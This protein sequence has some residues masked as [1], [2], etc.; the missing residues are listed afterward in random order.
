MEPTIQCICYPSE[1]VHTFQTKLLDSSIKVIKHFIS[2]LQQIFSIKI[3]YVLQ[4]GFMI[5][6]W[7]PI[8]LLEGCTELYIKETTDIKQPTPSINTH[9]NSIPNFQSFIQNYVNHL[10]PNSLSG[11]EGISSTIN[12]SNLFSAGTSNMSISIPETVNPESSEAVDESEVVDSE[13][14]YVSIHPEGEEVNSNEET[15]PEESLSET[16]TQTFSIPIPNESFQSPEHIQQLFTSLI[17]SSIPSH[18]EPS[19]EPSSE[20]N[21]SLIHI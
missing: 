6:E 8:T 5:D 20:T 4:N 2:L 14:E 15:Y 11:S 21:L 18:S 3:D 19:S 16:T 17:S 7:S 10:Q 13:D 12:L 9:L 1:T